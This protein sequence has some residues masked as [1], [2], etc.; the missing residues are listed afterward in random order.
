MESIQN[1]IYQVE[2]DHR[3]W[4]N[5]LTFLSNEMNFYKERISMLLDQVENEEKSE[6]LLELLH[7]LYVLKKKVLKLIER[8]NTHAYDMVTLSSGNG[9]LIKFIDG[10]HESTAAAVV[11]LKSLYKDLKSDIENAVMING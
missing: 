8:I 4:L 1:K 11:K 6:H 9:S 5:Y 3:R 10:M 2:F 7:R